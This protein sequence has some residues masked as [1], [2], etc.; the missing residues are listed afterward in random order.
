VP[1]VAG[2]FYGIKPAVTAIVLHAAHRIGSGTLK[3]RW[4]WGIALCLLRRDLR[5]RQPF[6]AIVLAA[7]LIGWLRRPL[8]AGVCARRRA[9]RGA[10]S[11]GRR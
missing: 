10:S 11:Y 7:A 9:W 6:P 1:L 3:N 2:L 5:L 8:A 4:L